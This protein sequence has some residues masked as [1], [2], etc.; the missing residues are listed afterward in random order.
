MYAMMQPYVLRPFLEKAVGI[1]QI[2]LSLKQCRELEI[3]LPPLALQTRFA[4]FVRQA[5]KS[6][7]VAQKAANAADWRCIFR[8]CSKQKLGGAANV[9]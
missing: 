3:P 6:K 8:I 1:R 2:N 7:F 9:L 5:D 4:D